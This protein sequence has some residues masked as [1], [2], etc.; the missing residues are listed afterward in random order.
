MT[1]RDV[2]WELPLLAGG[3]LESAEMRRTQ[4]H[5]DECSECARRLA[6]YENCLQM[7]NG[8]PAP[9]GKPTIRT[10]GECPPVWPAVREALI[11]REAERGV[12]RFNSGV[13][14]LATAATLL[15]SL[16]LAE[17]IDV[18]LTPDRSAVSSAGVADEVETPQLMWGQRWRDPNSP[19]V[20]QALP[21]ARPFLP[22]EVQPLPVGQ[23]LGI[24]S[25]EFD[26]TEQLGR[27]RKP[28]H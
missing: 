23:N 5:V 7:L 26:Q 16:S 22:G 15:A 6:S 2:E 25:H 9:Q 14:I 20:D 21:S 18:G 28:M 17:S 12:K 3:D 10:S 19:V 11:C 4:A 1:C 13:A 8:L 24:R 27:R